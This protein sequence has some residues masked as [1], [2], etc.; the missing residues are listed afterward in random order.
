M[1][2]KMTIEDLARIVQGGFEEMREEFKDVREHLRL[3][4]GRLDIIEQELMDIKKKLNEVIYRNEY[5]LLKERVDR[6]EKIVGAIKKR[7]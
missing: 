5:E 7:Y 4:D 1:A 6:I 3:I 2:K